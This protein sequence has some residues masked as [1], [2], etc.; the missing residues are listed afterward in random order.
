M[1]LTILAVGSA[2]VAAAVV[3]V[4][5][6][7]VISKPIGGWRDAIRYPVV[8]ISW[9]IVAACAAWLAMK[10]VLLNL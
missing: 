2:A 7:V 5:I 4:A 9:V 3:A 1:L 8:R 6:M 10:V